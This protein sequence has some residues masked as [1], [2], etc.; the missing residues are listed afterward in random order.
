MAI[1]RSKSEDFVEDIDQIWLKER[2]AL[3]GGD[4]YQ[5]EDAMKRAIEEMRAAGSER[6][7]PVLVD[8]LRGADV[9]IRCKSCEAIYWI[10]R[11]RGLDLVLPLLNDPESVVRWNTC[12]CLHDFRD[13]RAI[14]PL[15]DRLKHDPDPHVRGT[16]AYA[17][18]GIGSPE[19]IPALVE[20]VRS[21]H[22]ADQLG[23]TP[24]WCAAGALDEI[25]DTNYTRI[26]VTET[27]RK[28]A[29]YPRDVESLIRTAMEHYRSTTKPNAPDGSEAASN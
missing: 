15:I 1:S 21:D 8:L 3:L 27:L 17:L 29:P 18:G 22:E 4:G 6:L 25:L 11:H 24:S 7:F 14:E 20:T 19:A 13:A 26:K 28:L 2:L 12:G 10:D 16:A 5:G 9:E 23:Y